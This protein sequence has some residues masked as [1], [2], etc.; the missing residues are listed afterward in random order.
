MSIASPR[1]LSQLVKTR[2]WAASPTDG[3]TI[4][5]NDL[6]AEAEFDIQEKNGVINIKASIPGIQPD[7][8]DVHV[9]DNTVTIWGIIE[10][11]YMG[12]EQF[13]RV[14][15]LN[16]VPEVAMISIAVTYAGEL[17]VTIIKK[18]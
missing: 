15:V 1:K 10:F 18:R 9:Q 14:C 12:T 17:N 4:T 13:E 5:T 7:S 8:I 3:G 6:F 2:S 16:Y 11:E